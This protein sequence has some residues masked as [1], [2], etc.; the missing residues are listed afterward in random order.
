MESIILDLLW[1]S[2]HSIGFDLSFCS[3]DILPMLGYL[4]TMHGLHI[5][6]L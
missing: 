4:V 2:S 1:E 5:L 3:V 6:G